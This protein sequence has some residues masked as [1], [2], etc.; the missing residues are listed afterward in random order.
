MKETQK[1]WNQLNKKKLL[2]TTVDAICFTF[3][4]VV[5][6]VC[7]HEKIEERAARGLFDFKLHP[8]FLNPFGSKQR[9]KNKNETSVLR[10]VKKK[11][12]RGEGI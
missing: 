4:C 10:Y 1:Y 9:K 5:F 2:S 8:T 7:K 3:L 12:R 6:P 11:M